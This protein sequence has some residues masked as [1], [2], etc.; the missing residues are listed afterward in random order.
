MP[1]P[2]EKRRRLREGLASGRL[3]R[4]P[5]A[6]SPLVAKAAADHGFD[7]VYVSG[8]ALA[9]DL[10][11]PDIGLTTLTEVATR[12]G[13]I[14]RATD[15]PTL[16]DA[17]TGF[18]EV[19]NV[20]R[21]IRSLED[22]G[23]AGCHLEDQVNP[24]R[25]GHLDGKAVVPADEMVRRVAAA[26]KARTDP[27]FVVCARTDARA[28]EGLDA[29]IDRAKAY[30]DA[31]ADLVFPEALRDEAEFAAFRKAIDVPLLANMTEF[32]TS[33]NLTAAQLEDL[34][35]NLVIW[36]VSSL[37]A[38][39]GAVDELFAT[40]K[41][42]GT[43]ASLVERMQTR[44]RL[45]DLVDYASYNEFDQELFNFEVPGRES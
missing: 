36:P 6:F 29:A 38:A 26:V 3:Q 12:G 4:L 44:A 8:A 1:T 23:L 16:I 40:L 15:L 33:P 21:T 17:D 32:G 7:G 37:R 39:M 25:C 28:I 14:A 30:V 5:G 42:E 45:Y 41:T 19:G 34:G 43:Q 22:A 9:A 2:S 20:A 31:G 10:G 13:Q 18:G 24:K 11:L 35:Y 27:D